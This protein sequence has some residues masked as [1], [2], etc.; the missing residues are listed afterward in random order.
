M[1]IRPLAV[2]QW[3][4][5]PLGNGAVI[6]GRL[7]RVDRGHAHAPADSLVVTDYKTGVCR[8][9]SAS[10]LADD[11]GA[12]IY[13]LLASR[14]AGQPVTEICFH[15]LREGRQLRWPVET[16][17]LEL[18]QRRVLEA[19]RDVLSEQEFERRPG[20]H[21]NWCQHRDICPDG[22]MRLTREEL[23][24]APVEAVPF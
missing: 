10:D 4:R 6:G 11:R 7:D 21:C 23:L 17:D 2:E 16:D 18:L 1:A 20:H 9:D 14:A 22:E 3:L 15:Y 24:A 13:A 8:F 12:Q 5:A 19:T